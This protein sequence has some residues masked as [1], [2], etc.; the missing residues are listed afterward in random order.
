[1]SKKRSHITDKA[2]SDQEDIQAL[3]PDLLGRP[4]SSAPS[5]SRKSAATP[6]GGDQTSEEHLVLIGH[7]PVAEFLGMATVQA[8]DARSADQR[9]LIDEWMAAND[10]I[11]G[12]I[13]WQAGFAD[14]GVIVPIPT[15]LNK[16]VEQV[17]SD[18]IFQRSFSL[19]PTS[20]G[21]VEIDRLIPLQKFV[22]LKQVA[23]LRRRLSAG[24]TPRRIFKL[25]LPA[26]HPQPRVNQTRVAG[27][28]WVFASRTN[29]LRFLDAI[30]LGPDQIFGYRPQGPVAGVVGLVVGFGS[31]F[32]NVIRVG[33]RM[34]LANGTHRAF[35]LRNLGMTHIPCVVQNVSRGEEL[36]LVF[37]PQQLPL[38]PQ[39]LQGIRPPVFADFFDPFLSKVLQL[40]PFNF[41]VRVKFE[42]E[43]P[44]GFPYCLTA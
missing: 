17:E 2:G 38:V 15:Q 6:P 42:V 29:D 43:G 31:N 12:L 23:R 9:Q 32:V 25:C 41:Q 27:N 7:S 34:V 35:A 24:L 39:L 40:P 20:F 26:H 37:P 1:M 16:L 3:P 4:V 22:N 33:K 44:T 13:G 21:M 11:T 19:M 5:T 30:L 36:G 10:R 8:V 14:G 18:P 28:S